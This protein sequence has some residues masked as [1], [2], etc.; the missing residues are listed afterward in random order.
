MRDRSRIEEDTIVSRRAGGG[1]LS[2]SVG[3]M[4]IK[5]YAMVYI[6]MIV[7]QKIDKF[8][9]LLFNIYKSMYI[10]AIQI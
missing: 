10:C 1:V 5:W 2:C 9:I 3:K 4:Y 7:T 6:K 8:L